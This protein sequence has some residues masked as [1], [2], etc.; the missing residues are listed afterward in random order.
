M[1]CTRVRPYSTW[2]GTRHY[3]N[4]RGV[5]DRDQHHEEEQLSRAVLL[6]QRSEE[7]FGS[8]RC[9]VSGVSRHDNSRK[10]LESKPVCADPDSV[11]KRAGKRIMQVEHWK[12]GTKT[13]RRSGRLA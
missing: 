9:R 5:L 10:S 3:K 2:P 12:S 7:L 1:S 8:E 6:R 11:M 13:I 4:I